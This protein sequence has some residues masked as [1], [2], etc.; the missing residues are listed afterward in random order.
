[1]L[2]IDDL[3]TAPLRGLFFVL[4]EINAAVQA[5]RAA[6]ERQLV[7]ELAEL[8]RKLDSGQVTEADFEAG[9]DRLLHRLDALRGGGEADGGVRD[10]D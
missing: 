6:D 8:Y 10:R 3:L 2:L 1:M 7:V 9:E 5:E 4:Q